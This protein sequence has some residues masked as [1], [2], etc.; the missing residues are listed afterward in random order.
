MN[1][2]IPIDADLFSAINA[3]D[4]MAALL[5]EEDVERG[6]EIENSLEVAAL[7]RVKE[8]LRNIANNH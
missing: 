7:D 1:K 4:K 3:L 8:W 2:F 5:E 6:G